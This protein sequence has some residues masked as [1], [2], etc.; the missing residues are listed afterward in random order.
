VTA[1]TALRLESAT[2]MDADFWLDLQT[3][4][5]LW[6]ALRSPAAREID[7]IERGCRR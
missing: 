7:S 3:R 5:D 6:H 4:W 1:D 2:G